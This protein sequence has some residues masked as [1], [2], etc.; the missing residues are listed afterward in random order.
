M[1]LGDLDPL[2]FAQGLE[3]LSFHLLEI[4]NWLRGSESFAC[5]DEEIVKDS[6]SAVST[7][8]SNIVIN[9]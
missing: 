2:D 9:L 3:N 8:K 5:S 1:T 6:R 7:E 4:V